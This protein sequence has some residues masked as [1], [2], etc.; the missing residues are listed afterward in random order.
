MTRLKGVAAVLLLPFCALA[1]LLFYG[2]DNPSPAS[3]T[4][5]SQPIINGDVNAVINAA[6]KGMREL[7][8]FH[9]TVQGAKDG[10]PNLAIEGDLE[11]PNKVRCTYQQPGKEKGE[12]VVFG[13]DTYLK[14]PGSTGFVL[15]PGGNDPP[16][17]VGTLLDPEALTYY[18]L[19]GSDQKLVAEEKLNGIDTVHL[20]FI[21][22]PNLT[23][24]R[25]AILAGQPTPIPQSGSSGNFVGHMWVE[26][27]T[28]YVHRIQWLPPVP[29]QGTPDAGS[30]RSVT[31]DYSNFNEPVTPPIAPPAS[32]VTK[33]PSPVPQPTP[34]AVK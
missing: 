12:L 29:G 17:I 14:Q 16:N 7:K 3:P 1:V 24:S 34:T 9:F 21:F 5:V 30:Q 20:T 33:T 4:A 15:T 2:C 8:S 31:V 32:Y 23:D 11:R 13:K 28:N 22:D 10:A 18:A 26:K 25:A 19:L 27:G 6:D